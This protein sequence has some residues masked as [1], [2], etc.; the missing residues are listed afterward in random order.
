MYQIHIFE[1]QKN[2]RFEKYCF[3]IMSTTSSEFILI[4]FLKID[5]KISILIRK[6]SELGRDL[7]G[8]GDHAGEHE[9]VAVRAVDF[10]P[11]FTA[12]A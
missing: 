9:R 3:I 1:S 12:G 5:N 8:A 4:I 10:F 11:V 6:W 2:S 7:E